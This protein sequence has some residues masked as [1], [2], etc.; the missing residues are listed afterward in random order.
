MR[1]SPSLTS[2]LNLVDVETLPSEWVLLSHSS[3]VVWSPPTSHLTSLRISPLQLIPLV[4]VV[5][6]YWPDE[7]SPVPPSAFTTSHT[8]YTGE[9]FTAAFQA[10]HRFCCLRH[11]WRARL[12]L[13]PFGST[14]RCCKFHFMLRAAV[15]LPFLREL[16]R[17]DTISHPTASVACYPASWHLPELDFHQW[18]DDDFQDTPRCV[19]QLDVALDSRR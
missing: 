9:F 14:C 16:Q 8:P 5:V 15:L 6:G 4:T 1:H 13:F 3:T 11:A 19:G 17:F 2:S 12:S 7:I 18:A 10:L